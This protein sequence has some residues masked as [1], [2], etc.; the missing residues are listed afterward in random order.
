MI[1]VCHFVSAG[2]ISVLIAALGTNRDIAYSA[3]TALD[4]L[5]PLLESS[6]KSKV[7]LQTVHRICNLLCPPVHLMR[8]PRA[9]GQ[10]KLRCAVLC[11]AVLCCA[12]LCC[13]MLCCDPVL[14]MQYRSSH[15][16]CC[17]MQLWQLIQLVGTHTNIV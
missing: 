6:A 2:G 3:F 5:S 4:S 11:C 9:A 1:S 15:A 14:N 13:A 12:V 7:R 17:A 8:E 16:S 10:P